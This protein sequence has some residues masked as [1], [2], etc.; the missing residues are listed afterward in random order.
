M[1][2]R[3]EQRLQIE[4]VNTLRA[5]APPLE[6][7]CFHV[8]NGGYRTPREAAI[9]KALGVIPGIPDL[10]CLWSAGRVGF[11]ELKAHNGALTNIQGRTHAFLRGMG[12]QVAVV[13]SVEQAID[14][15]KEWG[16]P[17]RGR[18]AA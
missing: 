2:Q 4:L 18:I 8:P 13:R 1:T 5:I 11:I 6:F 12:F 9:F 16:A 17:I 10:V 7:M 15:L 3:P 14:T